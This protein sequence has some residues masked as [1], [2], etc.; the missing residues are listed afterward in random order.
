MS[1][2]LC[3]SAAWSMAVRIM[4]ELVSD[5]AVV[6]RGR[7]ERSLL[8]A[9]RF[10]QVGVLGAVDELGRLRGGTSEGITADARRNIS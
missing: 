4:C 1:P 10:G 7:E 6:P 2:R 8:L 3:S 9:L 5:A